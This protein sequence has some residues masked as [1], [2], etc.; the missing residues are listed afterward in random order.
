MN[1]SPIQALAWIRHV[2]FRAEVGS[3]NDLAIELAG[4][5][6]LPVPAVVIAKRQTAG[7]GQGA[8]RW[9]S[10]EGGAAFSLVIEPDTE[11]PEK[12]EPEKG[13]PWEGIIERSRWP[14]LPLTMATAVH[15]ALQP[16]ALEAV[17]GIKWPND[18][19]AAGRKI[20]G[21]LVEAPNLP[22]LVRR[23]LV[24]GVGVNVNNSW[25]AAPPE[26]ASQGIS[27]CDLGG[28]KYEIGSVVADIL[29]HFQRRL[30]QLARRDDDLSR[31]W[32]GLC[33]LRGRTIRV[34]QAGQGDQARTIMGIC[35]GIDA[36]GALVIGGQDGPQRLFTGRVSVA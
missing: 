3:T 33:L 16:L 30:E 36:D 35:E 34:E 29:E 15:D 12:E 20:A 19:Y 21:V 14:A 2:E 26:L 5:T 27:L 6:R 31:D 1:I 8:R 7:R 4:D 9:W 13:G 10:G 28:K 24:I 11:N 22:G 23:R 18:L 32:R 17:W 25:S